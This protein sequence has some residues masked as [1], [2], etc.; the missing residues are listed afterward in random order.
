MFMLFGILFTVV[1]G[2]ILHYTF[3]WSG[4]NLLV[5]FL[6]PTN[7]S[8]FEHLKLLLTPYLLWM[9][10]EYVQYGQYM[11]AFVP[12]KVISLYAGMFLMVVLHLAY[13]S[14]SKD[15]SAW[16]S[17]LVFV[18]SVVAA[19][20]LSEF[21][22]TLTLFDSAGMEIFFDAILV[23]TIMAFAAFTI[24]PPRFWLFEAA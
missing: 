20:I 7:E 10:V 12:A 21:L 3:E 1:L 15:P 22:M 14:L 2:V 16:G 5:A 19:F 17:A 18:I 8:F 11:H 4:R 23:L 13:T 9:L 24:Y 6:A